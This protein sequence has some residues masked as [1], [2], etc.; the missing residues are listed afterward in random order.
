VVLVPNGRS[1]NVAANEQEV[2]PENDTA[3]KQQT[4][5]NPEDVHLMSNMI[6]QTASATS[7]NEA[8]I[9]SGPILGA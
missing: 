5:H 9:C 6:A 7:T 4:Q 1:A 3:K 8:P 2:I